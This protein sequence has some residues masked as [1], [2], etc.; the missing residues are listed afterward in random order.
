MHKGSRSVCGPRW[1][2]NQMCEFAAVK[3]VLMQQQCLQQCCQ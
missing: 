1:A 2:A 3:V